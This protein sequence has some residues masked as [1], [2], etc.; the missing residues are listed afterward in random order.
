MCPCSI[1]SPAL[2]SPFGHDGIKVGSV[3]PGGCFRRPSLVFIRNGVLQ[4]AFSAGTF[5]ERTCQGATVESVGL[6]QKMPDEGWL[7]R[8]RPNATAWEK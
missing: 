3:N 7:Q 6:Q 4:V 1:S 8:I 2:Q 5:G